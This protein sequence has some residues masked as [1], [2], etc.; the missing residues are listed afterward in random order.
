MAKEHSSV[1]IRVN[2]PGCELSIH[3]EH[4]GL[5]NKVKVTIFLLPDFVVTCLLYILSIICF[6]S[7]VR[8]KLHSV[9]LP[10]SL[11]LL[12]FL[13]SLTV[14]ASSPPLGSIS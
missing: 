11:V 2:F 13:L 6:L 9:E 14:N 4:L 10:L 8:R 3:F 5:Y 12:T 1:F 7:Q